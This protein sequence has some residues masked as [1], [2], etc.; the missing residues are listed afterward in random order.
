MTKESF[1]KKLK[2]KLEDREFSR[3]EIEEIIEDYAM[4]IDEAIDRGEDEMTFV[5][6]LGEPRHIARSLRKVSDKSR[7][8]D[9]KFIALSPFI[10]LIL[11]FYAG[12]AHQA[13][14]PA[15]M[16]FL[17]IPVSA[18]VL[19]VKS[20]L[21]KLTAL[22]VFIALIAFML[23]GT[24]MNLWHPMWALFL[25]IPAFGFLNSRV[26]ITKLFG[27]Y[28]FL[29]IAAFITYTLIV[30]PTHLYAFL[31]LAPIP[32]MGLLTGE[33]SIVWNSDRKSLRAL[34]ISLIATVLMLII[35]IYIGVAFS[36][37]HPTWLMFLAIPFTALLYAK[38]MLK[39][40]IGIVA[41]TPF[42]AVAL[43][44]LWG[45]YGNAYAYSWL[46]FLL[47]PMTAILFDQEDVGV[48]VEVNTNPDDE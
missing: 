4:L 31:L 12:F 2:E 47:I 41:F 36:I 23:I 15:W 19:E 44:I 21:E 11:F 42:I 24:Y 16:A 32:I 28:T 14:H 45:E 39:D 30:E 25:I 5:A 26:L 6:K 9:S 10:A 3:K 1:I 33:I 34:I 20:L 38:F 35:Y 43:F 18:I 27:V 48:Q 46:V 13:W 40:N 29:A 17:L 37:W 7:K 8:S 22:S